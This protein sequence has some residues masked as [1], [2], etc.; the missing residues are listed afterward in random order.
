MLSQALHG[1]AI[2]LAS[3]TGQLSRQ[4]C[5]T[6]NKGSRNKVLVYGREV[7][8]I[9]YAPLHGS[10]D[11][12]WGDD[13][14][15]RRSCSGYNFW[16]WGSP[17]SWASKRQQSVALS[18]CEAE[19]MAASDAARE[20]VW[21]KRLYEMD[22]GYK[23]LTVETRGDLSEKEYQGGKPLTIFEDNLGCIY[24]SRNPVNHKSNKHVEIRYHFVREKVADGTLKLVKI[25]TK[26]NTADI[27]TKATTTA[28]FVYLR[29][30]MLHDREKPVHTSMSEPPSTAS[31]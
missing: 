27:H 20:A 12:S 10:V 31:R 11:G 26:E 4:F 23:D 9:P 24:L 18:S 16:A 7:P 2:T 30:K 8:G 28:T 17:I 15:D 5:A 19:Y 1:S 22:L 14:D 3:S 25:D 6:L 29:D 13:P 21:L